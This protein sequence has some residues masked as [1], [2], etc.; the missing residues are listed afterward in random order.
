MKELKPI[1][2]SEM[3][4]HGRHLN[5]MLEHAKDMQG[6]AFVP[7]DREC[8]QKRVKELESHK[9]GFAEVKEIAKHYME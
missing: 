6:R 2:L 4:K 3:L 8:W 9:I 5:E 7:K 1:S